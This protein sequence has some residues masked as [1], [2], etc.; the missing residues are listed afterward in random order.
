MDKKDD[1]LFLVQDDIYY[2]RNYPHRIFRVGDYV[3]KIGLNDVLEG[4]GISWWD[5][6]GEI[7]SNSGYDEF[8]VR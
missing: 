5:I 7:N 3:T 4:N 6:Y 1:I 2:G 8:I